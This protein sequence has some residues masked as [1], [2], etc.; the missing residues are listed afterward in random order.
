MYYL[1]II[2]NYGASNALY[3][4]NT[5]DE[6]LIRFHSELAYRHEDRKQTV[7]CILNGEG[8]T[9]RNEIYTAPVNAEPEQ[10]G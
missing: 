6:A 3:A 5:L 1:A 7:C 10:E 2:Q 4:Y 8:Q 9:L